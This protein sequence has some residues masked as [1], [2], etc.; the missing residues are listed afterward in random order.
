MSN[1]VMRRP[2]PAT[3]LKG[4]KKIHFCV[5]FPAVAPRRLRKPNTRRLYVGIIT[6]GDAGYD[7]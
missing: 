3:S 2:K 4:K 6:L 7:S 1:Y 5:G